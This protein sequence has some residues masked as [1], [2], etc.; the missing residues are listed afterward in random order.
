MR[1]LHDEPLRPAVKYWTD[2][3]LTLDFN[4]EE[5]RWLDWSSACAMLHERLADYLAEVE[6]AV[7]ALANVYVELNEEEILSSLLIANWYNSAPA[8]PGTRS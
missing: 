7:R 1:Y 8:I 2:L 6:S 5:Q 3:Q 4:E